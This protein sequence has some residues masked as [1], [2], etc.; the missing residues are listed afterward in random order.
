M[1]QQP[2]APG[3]GADVTDLMPKVGEDVSHLMGAASAP[4]PQRPDFSTTNATDD[5]GNPIV[6]GV[7]SVWNW[8]NTSPVGAYIHKAAQDIAQAMDQPTTSGKP[9]LVQSAASA[10]VPGL[11]SSARMA[12]VI[13]TVLPG[14]NLRARV[15]GAQAGM[16]E[17]AGNVAESMS[18]PMGV[19][20]WLA[21]LGPESS[22]VKHIPG[23]ER[24]L[25]LPSVQAAQR[26][27][28]GMSG[29]GF[30]V[31]GASTLTDP[32]LPAS[33]RVM[34][35]PEMAAGAAGVVSSVAGGRRGAAP[36]RGRSMPLTPEEQASNAFADQQGIPL[37]AATRTGSRT[38]RAMQKRVANSMGGEGTA[39]DMARAQAE[40]LRRV[41]Q[42]LADRTGAQPITPE[43]AG[44]ARRE[45][46]QANER[47]HGA[48][49]DEAY[50][51]VRDIEA[52]A[53]EKVHTAPAGSEA[54][55]SI[56]KRLADSAIVEQ[57]D[58][59]G[60]P[61]TTRK[62]APPTQPELYVMRQIEAELEAMPFR[63]EQLVN[64]EKLDDP[65]EGSYYVSRAPGAPVFHDIAKQ[66]PGT[67]T[68][69]REDVLERLR[70]TLDTGK[71]NPASRAAWDVAKRR[72]AASGGA[73]G[74]KTGLSLPDDVPLLGSSRTV[75][76]PVHLGPAQRALKPLYDLLVRQRELTGSLMGDSG[77]ALVA[78]DRLMS[79]PEYES[80][81]VVDQALGDLKTFARTSLPELRTKG[82][83][84]AAQ[85]IK[86]LETQVRAKAEA[87]GAWPALEEGRKATIERAGARD[88]LSKMDGREGVALFDE[89]VAPKD[90]NAGQLREM[91]ARTPDV[92]PK[93]ARA[94]LDRQMD[95]AMSTGRFDHAATLWNEWERMEKETKRVLFP[96]PNHRADVGRFFLLAKRL[97]DNPNPSGTAHVNNVFN[98]A[99]QV[100]TYPLAKLL[101][102]PE[103]ARALARFMTKSD[104]A[105]SAA[106]PLR[107]QR[108]RAALAELATATRAAGLQP[109]GLA[110]G[111]DSE[112]TPE[113]R[114]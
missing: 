112:Q 82:Q 56:L 85:A 95:R 24:M 113:G 97:A 55:R 80:L 10:L 49:A 71:W 74:P 1:P 5:E 43:A 14:G 100:V 89:L 11:N 41:G 45:A 73:P 84:V 42:D 50:G 48:Y 67:S 23:L 8:L 72:L 114:R 9:S 17:G 87:I 38:A 27:V 106:P 79:A 76:A 94:W 78:L 37:D 16:A 62:G 63:K 86:A 111:A 102:T 109:A 59:D 12:D 54:E 29:A 104:A 96:D 33:E 15:Q 98:V 107:V 65:L 57:T 3:L 101:Y 90:R 31:H 99:S 40:G 2:T 21:G 18:T 22:F 66:L 13:D 83:G 60:F 46:M 30:T 81:S 75:N 61:T 92:A 39:E 34:G 53:P 105:K 68:P 19:A 20:L 58:A 7:S 36:P 26:A 93:V 64:G 35:L 52:G 77:R 88:I 91:L 4:P 110:G 70:D 28:Q 108:Q 44:L 6:A 32:E 103:G 51:L 25:A 47:Q 69:T